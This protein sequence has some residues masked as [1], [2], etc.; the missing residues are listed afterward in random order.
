MTIELSRTIDVVHINNDIEIGDIT[1]PQW[2]SAKTAAI[3]KYW[4]GQIAPAGRHFTAGL[5]WSDQNIYA[6][7][8]ASQA[9]SLVVSQDPDLTRKTMGLWD[10]DVC[11]IFLA[12][13]ASEPRRYFEFELAPSCEWVDLSID[14][15]S[16]TRRTDAEYSSN[17]RVFASIEESRIVMALTIPWSTFGAKPS[18]GDVWAGNLFRCVGR[19]PDRGYLAYNPTLTDTPNFHVPDRFVPFKFTKG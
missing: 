11:E 8:D 12:P 13:D 15:T 4:S 18:P 7:F 9:E 3:T 5:L 16:G 1:H 6:R 14:S 17:M 10:R 19:D 2:S